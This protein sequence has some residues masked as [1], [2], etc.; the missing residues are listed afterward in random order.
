MKKSLT[1]VLGLALASSMALADK[2]EGGRSPEGGRGKGDPEQRMQRM[3][4]HLDLSDEQVTQMREIRANGGGR[5]EMRGVLTEDQQTKAREHRQKRKA[6]QEN[7]QQE[8]SS[9]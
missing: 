9:D 8:S 5:E 4:K 7:T 6:R 2:S 3:Q 1:I